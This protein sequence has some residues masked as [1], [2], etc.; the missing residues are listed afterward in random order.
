VAFLGR[1]LAIGQQRAADVPDAANVDA[2]A[3]G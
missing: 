3:R 2:F 1:V